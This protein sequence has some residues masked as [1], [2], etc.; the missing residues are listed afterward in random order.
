MTI[1]LP[2][3]NNSTESFIPAL[4][5]EAFYSIMNESIWNER[6]REKGYYAAQLPVPPLK[7]RLRRM[8]RSW[9]FVTREKLALK[10]APW[11]EP[12]DWR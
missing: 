1:N 7:T 12:D 6:M 3:P 2:P 10:I 9:V 5:R 11:L 8:C 4:Y